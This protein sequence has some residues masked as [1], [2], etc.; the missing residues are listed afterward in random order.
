[1]KERNPD[2]Q[3][4][5]KKST[6]LKKTVMSKIL[7]IGVGDGGRNAVQRMKE[8]G[9]PDA[10]YIT[11]GCL[12]EDYVDGEFKQA[13]PNS[14]IPHYNLITMNGLGISNTDNPKV[15]AELAENA[16]DQIRGIIEYSFNKDAN[17]LISKDTTTSIDGLYLIECTSDNHIFYELYK[18][19]KGERLWK[20]FEGKKHTNGLSMVKPMNITNIVLEADTEWR[21]GEIAPAYSGLYIVAYAFQNNVETYYGYH[22]TYG[23]T[24]TQLSIQ[25][26][27]KNY[28]LIYAA[29]GENFRDLLM[30]LVKSR[31]FKSKNDEIEWENAMVL[32]YY[33]VRDD[34]E[35]IS[36]KKDIQ[37]LELEIDNE[38]KGLFS[39]II[40]FIRGW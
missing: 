5:V 7:I 24:E 30:N 1:M 17:G 34:T 36:I 27:K 10:N 2:R 4:R 8:I 40:R 28:A 6:T 31:G 39:R 19:R 14:D 29:Q 13:L 15:F 32:A 22:S 18:Y 11:F 38:R 20:Y 23:G 33:I 26:D 9:I 35:L 37:E 3:G 21:Q 12:R 25:Y 16:K